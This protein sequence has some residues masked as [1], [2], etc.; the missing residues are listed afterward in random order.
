MKKKIMVIYGTR[1]ELIKLAPV[2]LELKKS[3]QDFELFQL[4]TAQHREMLDQMLE[5]FALKP[6]R[7]L[8]IMVQNQTLDQLSSNVMLKVSAIFAEI[9]PHIVVIQ[10]DTTTAMISAL[11][12]FYKKIPVAHVEAGLRTGDIYN[13][14]PEE[15]NR[16][17]VA[18]VASYH[19][20]PTKL[21]SENLKNE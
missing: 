11:A 19:F 17:I 2:I 5:L 8:N 14:F 10:G 13:P 4:A 7:D 18:T 20:P 16:K 9:E 6:D 12:A 15:I 21:S 1:P 3:P